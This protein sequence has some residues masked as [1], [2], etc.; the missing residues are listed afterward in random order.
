MMK[1]LHDAHIAEAVRYNQVI[2][3]SEE[4]GIK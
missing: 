2:T 4:K 1:R 3:I